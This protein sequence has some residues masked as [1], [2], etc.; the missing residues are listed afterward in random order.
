MQETRLDPQ[1]PS[2]IPMTL[3]FSD[4]LGRASKSPSLAFSR[5]M[6][7]KPQPALGLAPAS[8]LLD[9]TRPSRLAGSI[10]VDVDSIIPRSPVSQTTLELFLDQILERSIFQG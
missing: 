2:Q 9:D 1:I 3:R 4:S 8:R 7:V 6:R 10:N 5:L